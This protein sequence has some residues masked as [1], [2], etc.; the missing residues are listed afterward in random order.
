MWDKL[1]QLIF[2]S[3]GGTALAMSGIFVRPD[4]VGH[5]SEKM[6]DMYADPRGSEWLDVAVD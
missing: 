4:H 1:M 6:T 3:F 2:D 5:K